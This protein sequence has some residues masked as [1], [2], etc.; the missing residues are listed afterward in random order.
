MLFQPSSVQGK[1]LRRYIDQ[2]VYE[3]AIYDGRETLEIAD[4]DVWS[5]IECGMTIFMSITLLR[6]AHKDW[7]ECPVC[8]LRSRLRDSS[9]KFII[10]WYVMI[11]F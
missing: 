10:H 1:K 5:S 4:Q 11:G 2:G 7:R 9:E 6:S 3:L 8:H